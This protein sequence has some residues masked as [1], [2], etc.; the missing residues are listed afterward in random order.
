MGLVGGYLDDLRRIGGLK[1]TDVANIAN[2]SKATVSRWTSGVA[3]PHPH[4]ELVL[5]DLRYIVGRLEEYYEPGEIRA[6]L[7]ARHPQLEGRRA[8]DLIGAGQSEAV[9]AVIGRLDTGAYL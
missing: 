7:F 6:W 2:V 9:L 4:T 3:A 1:G 5:S 8:I